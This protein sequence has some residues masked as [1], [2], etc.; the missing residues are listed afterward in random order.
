MGA[1]DFGAGSIEN[2]AED[3]TPRASVRGL[4]AGRASS[5]SYSEDTSFVSAG[6]SMAIF[7]GFL[8]FGAGRETVEGPEAEADA[9]GVE[10]TGREC[11]RGLFWDVE[12]CD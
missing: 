7:L 3:P 6:R 11:D 10:G 9:D 4:L 12:V 5:P 2:R 1:A 8:A